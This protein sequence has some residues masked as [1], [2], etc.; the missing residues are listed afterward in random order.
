MKIKDRKNR[1]KNLIDKGMSYQRVGKIF[2]I[3]RQR[4]FQIVKETEK[5]NNLEIQNLF[6]SVKKRD[7]FKCQLCDEK[8]K[9]KLIIHHIDECPSNNHIMNLVTVC[10]SCHRGIHRLN[11]KRLKQI[12]IKGKDLK[13]LRKK[14][15]MSSRQLEEL[16]GVADS[17]ICRVEKGSLIMSKE[18]WDKIRKILNTYKRYSKKDIDILAKG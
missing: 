11:G 14:A 13:R 8:N 10:K 17:I 4:V 16:S 5:N 7:N 18:S 1:M 12:Y 15:G 9:E 2:N 6:K 3:S